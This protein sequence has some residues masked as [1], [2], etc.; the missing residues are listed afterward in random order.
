MCALEVTGRHVTRVRSPYTPP[1]CMFEAA[2]TSQHTEGLGVATQFHF[3]F[4]FFSDNDTLTVGKNVGVP[5]QI[6][7]LQK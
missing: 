7:Q 3:F 5:E 2:V 4:F 6:S 1:P